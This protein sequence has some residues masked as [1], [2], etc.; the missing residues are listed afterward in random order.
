MRRDD[1]LSEILCEEHYNFAAIDELVAFSL[2]NQVEFSG[3]VKLSALDPLQELPVGLEHVVTEI[4]FLKWLDAI[5]NESML[6]L[7][8]IEKDDE[9]LVLEYGSAFVNDRFSVDPLFG[10]QVS[11]AVKTRWLQNSLSG[12]RGEGV[13]G[14]FCA[15]ALAG[16]VTPVLDRDAIIIDLI[17]VG[18]SYRGQG[19]GKNLI[20]GL[21]QH[22]RL[23]VLVST[24]DRNIP[25]INLYI[26]TGFKVV[27]STKVFHYHS[28][29]R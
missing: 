11:C 27:S 5:P 7:K 2:G 16:I 13:F 4:K 21:Q 25:S 17:A 28:G 3:T 19:I 9:S 18:A 12:V 29:R 8:K 1:F 14:I 20:I 23:P 26:S 6:E 24:Q 22:F 10:R 15:G